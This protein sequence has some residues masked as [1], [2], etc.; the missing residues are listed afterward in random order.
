MR[1]CASTR[2]VKS[3][4]RFDIWLTTGIFSQEEISVTICRHKQIRDYYAVFFGYWKMCGSRIYELSYHKEL[5]YSHWSSI[6]L[7]S[8]RGGVIIICWVKWRIQ[9]STHSFRHWL[10]WFYSPVKRW[11]TDS[12]QLSLLFT[13]TRGQWG[14]GR[15]KKLSHFKKDNKQSRVPHRR[16]HEDWKEPPTHHLSLSS[17][18]SCQ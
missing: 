14:I 17:I 18:T 2:S 9:M 4:F 11:E 8:S 3:H 1:K 13:F 15:M 6:G 7:Q 5:F 10:A 12:T 16:H